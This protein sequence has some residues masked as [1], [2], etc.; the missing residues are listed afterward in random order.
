MQLRGWRA[1]S[2]YPTCGTK[3]LRE[4]LSGLGIAKEEPPL[5]ALTSNFSSMDLIASP[6]LGNDCCGT[7]T[8]FKKRGRLLYCL[9]R[10]NR[11]LIKKN[12]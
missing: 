9:R 2:F 10:N 11:S 12:L 4:G 7:F 6:P 3:P 5:I 8:H 1:P